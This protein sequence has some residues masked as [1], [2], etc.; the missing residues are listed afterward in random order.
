MFLPVCAEMETGFRI[1]DAISDWE[2]FIPF[3]SAPKHVGAYIGQA[4]GFVA[5]NVQHCT[6]R[7]PGKAKTF[8]HNASSAWWNAKKGSEQERAF[9]T[10]EDTKRK[11]R[12]QF[13]RKSEIAWVWTGKRWVPA[14]FYAQHGKEVA[15]KT[16][17][18]FGTIYINSETE[19]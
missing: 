5:E 1:W 8:H 6:A 15:A 7:I 13:K 9:Y 4:S 19:K 2:V 16:E 18:V 14:P 3:A 17:R 10:Y 12:I 11:F